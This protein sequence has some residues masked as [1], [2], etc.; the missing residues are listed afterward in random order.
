MKAMGIA[1]LRAR[2]TYQTVDVSFLNDLRKGGNAK[3]VFLRINFDFND[4]CFT[5]YGDC[6]LKAVSIY[7]KSFAKDIAERFRASSFDMSDKQRW[8]I[9]FAF[10]KI[11]KELGEEIL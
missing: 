8:C 6:I 2:A 10:I 11:Q 9:A 3:E 5:N 1:E 7:D 4:R